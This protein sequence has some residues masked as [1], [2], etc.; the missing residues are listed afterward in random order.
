MKR[1]VVIL[2]AGSI[3][4]LG[5]HQGGMAKQA[6]DHAALQNAIHAKKAANH[7]K[8]EEAKKKRVAAQAEIKNKDAQNQA[9][10]GKHK[11]GFEKRKAEW[12]LKK[13]E[14]AKKGSE[15]VDARQGWQTKRIEHGIAKGYL[16]QDEINTLNSQQQSIA[17]L[18]AS[19][20]ADGALSGSDFKQLQTALN[21]ASHCIWAEKHD[22]DGNQMAAYAFGKNVFAKDEV[23]AKL[24]DL[25]LPKA[26]ARTI[27]KD[28][29]RMLEIEGILATKDLS[30]VDRAAYQDEYNTLLNNYFV[31][32]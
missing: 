16:T 21:S 9:D 18:E 10:A 32:K 14:L 20:K 4:L 3:V 1:I 12:E 23:T 5:S 2:V 6:A 26:E 13:S 31:V 29:G 11:A 22:T 27:V 19:L 17:S 30:D 8:L 15:K 28:F 25:N 7:G 24:A